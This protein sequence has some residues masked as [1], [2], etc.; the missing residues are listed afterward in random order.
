[1]GPTVKSSSYGLN[2]E[3]LLL[4]VRVRGRRASCASAGF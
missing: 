1:M 2:G 4:M 3:E